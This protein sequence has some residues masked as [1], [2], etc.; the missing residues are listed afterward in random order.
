MS[1]L[2]QHREVGT[3]N[4]GELRA[5]LRVTSLQ[6][7]EWALDLTSEGGM[8]IWVAMSMEAHTGA[9][10]GALFQYVHTHRR[11]AAAAMALKS[12]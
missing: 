3:A 5:S 8:G 4:K 10:T 11:G 9:S 7:C 12:G 1:F 6:N 2:N